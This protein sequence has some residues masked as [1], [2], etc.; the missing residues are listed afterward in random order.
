MME[1]EESLELTIQDDELLFL[2]ESTTETQENKQT[3]EPN[4]D[5]EENHE[6]ISDSKNDIIGNN[7]QNGDSGSQRAS[8]EK[9]IKLTE[10]GIESPDCNSSKRMDDVLLGITNI[11]EDELIYDSDDEMNETKWGE[12]NDANLPAQNTNIGK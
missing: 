11:D 4:V 9:N 5:K 1:A 10:N 8:L 12:E 6:G 2:E 3:E 7:N